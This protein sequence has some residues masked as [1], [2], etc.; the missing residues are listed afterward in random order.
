MSEEISNEVV[1][2][3][4][5]ASVEAETPVEQEARVVQSQEE[6]TEPNAPVV[7]IPSP[8]VSLDNPIED[9][10][11]DDYIEDY[12]GVTNAIQE[13]FKSLQTQRGENEEVKED[14]RFLST[15]QFEEEWAKREQ[16]ILQKFEQSQAEKTQRQQQMEMLRNQSKQVTEQY[17]G[18]LAQ[19]M[20]KAGIDLKSDIGELLSHHAVDQFDRLHRQELSLKGRSVL[21][22]AEMAQLTQKHW[23]AIEP[24]VKKFAKKA[25]TN[26]TEN[27]GAANQ[28]QTIT[29]KRPTMNEQVLKQYNEKKR[30]GKLELSDAIKMLNAR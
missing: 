13:G 25:E 2:Q 22:P 30:S 12:S 18:Q 24:M 5:E 15:Q 9:D 1:E 8:V 26:S 20:E 10:D 16:Q 28:G 21:T 23:P 14:D 4:I 7:E 3:P 17:I 6:Q 27:L 29:H 11:D 19:S